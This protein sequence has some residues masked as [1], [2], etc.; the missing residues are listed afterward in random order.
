MYS[1]EP[2]MPAYFIA[3]IEV[4]KP[5]LYAQY[6][7]KA[8]PIVENFGGRYVFR[9]ESI[10]PLSGDWRPSRMI[11]IAFENKAKII[12]CFSSDEYAQI[13][14]LRENSTQSRSIIVEC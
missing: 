7:E 2:A 1:E 6:V 13:S 5:E 4:E 10:H 14:F 3:E 12:E 9:S 11:M 8:A